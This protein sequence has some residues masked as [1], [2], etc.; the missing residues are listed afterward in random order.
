MTVTYNVNQY[1]EDENGN[2]I[3]LDSSV[4][5]KIAENLVPIIELDEDSGAYVESYETVVQDVY[6]GEANEQE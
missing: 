6:E 3:E 4:V 2:D 5:K 1:D